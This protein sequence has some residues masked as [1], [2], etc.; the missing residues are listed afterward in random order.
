M[1]LRL[2]KDITRNEEVSFT[3]EGETITAPLGEPLAA[4]LWAAG[5]K[6]LRYAPMD[7]RT[8]GMF[9]AIGNCQE[10]CVLING[11]KAEACRAPVNPGMDVKRLRGY[12]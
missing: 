4:A 7:G 11:R 8:R 2:S 10:C 1:S 6:T 12:Q 3:F 9:C 5:I